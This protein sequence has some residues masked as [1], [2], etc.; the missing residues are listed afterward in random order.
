MPLTTY[1]PRDRRRYKQHEE[2]VLFSANVPAGNY[3]YVQDCDGKVWVAPD[4]FHMHPRVLGRAQPAVSAGELTIGDDGDV[5]IVN[6]VSGTFQCASDS[7][8]T[9]VGGLILQGA[10]ITPEA[11]SR[12]ED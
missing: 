9:T 1:M 11:V 4:G 7:L 12:H 6:N 8:I 10:I 3:V 5:F 2:S